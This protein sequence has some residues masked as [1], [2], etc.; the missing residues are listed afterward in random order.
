MKIK[1]LKFKKK[2]TKKKKY[3]HQNL[4]KKMKKK[5]KLLINYLI[6]KNKINNLKNNILKYIY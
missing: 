6:N 5:N 4:R 1:I 3:Y 2:V